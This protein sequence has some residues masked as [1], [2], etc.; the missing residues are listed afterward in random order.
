VVARAAREGDDYGHAEPFR[1]PDALA[2]R[3]VSGLRL[4]SFWMQRIVVARQRADLEARVRDPLPEL[5]SL[6]FVG[7]QRLR[8]EMVIA[9]PAAGAELNRGDVLQ[10]ANAAQ[11]RRRIEVAEHGREQ[12]KFHRVSARVAA[13]TGVH[14]PPCR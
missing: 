7:E 11:H 5:A 10:G 6:R 12:S 1:Q 13:P 14:T 9:R 4:R 2:N 8:I 3:V